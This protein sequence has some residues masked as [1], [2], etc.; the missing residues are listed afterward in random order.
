MLVKDEYIVA[1]EQL[2]NRTFQTD[3]ELS[4]ERSSF[5]WEWGI[6]PHSLALLSFAIVKVVRCLHYFPHQRIHLYTD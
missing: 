4:A 1:S 2:R 6:D 3:E 5:L